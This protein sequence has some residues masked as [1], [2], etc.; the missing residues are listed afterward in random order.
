MNFGVIQGYLFLCGLVL[1]HT[2][3]G[4]LQLLYVSQRAVGAAFLLLGAGGEW[5]W[6]CDAAW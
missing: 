6:L 4:A 2:R 3:F 1:S 5:R